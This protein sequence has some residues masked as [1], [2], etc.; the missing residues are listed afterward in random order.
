M[1][2]RKK[3]VSQ[4]RYQCAQSKGE[5]RKATKVRD[6]AKQHD[7]EGM[8]RYL[9]KGTLVITIQLVHNVYILKVSLKHSHPHLA[10]QQINIPSDVREIIIKG[11]DW[12]VRD[13]S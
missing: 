12:R 7:H 6:P 2:V 1:D 4:F 13:V 3:K 9:C 10:Y 8:L 11:K 5:V